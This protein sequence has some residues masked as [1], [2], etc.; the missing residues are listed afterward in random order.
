MKLILAIVSS[1]DSSVVSAAL[2]KAGFS[3]TKLATTGGFLM[4]GN[5]TFIIGTDDEKVDE[6]IE[7]IGR[8]SKK[9]KQMVPSSASYGVGMYTSFPVEV[10]VG[11]ATIFVMDVEQFK[12]L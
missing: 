1:D 3:V 10:T 8:H 5:T 4:S 11:G 6:V 7:V 2:T 12:K 9:R